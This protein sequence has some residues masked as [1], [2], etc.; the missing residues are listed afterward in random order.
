MNLTLNVMALIL[1][2]LSGAISYAIAREVLVPAVML[3]GSAI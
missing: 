3:I 2:G 1:A